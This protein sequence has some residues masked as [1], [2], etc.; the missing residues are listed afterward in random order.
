MYAAA[1]RVAA[2]HDLPDDWLNDAV[3]GFLPGP[4]AQ[5]QTLYDEPGL[6]VRVASPTYLLAMKLLAAR[7]ERDEDDIRAL[8]RLCGFTTAAE[9][10]D[11]VTRVYPHRALAAKVQ[12]LLEEMFSPG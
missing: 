6:T 8:Y 1:R 12:F 4:D 5:A 7:V 3:K 11:L 9:G 10:I 2:E